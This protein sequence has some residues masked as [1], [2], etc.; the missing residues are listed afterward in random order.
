[1]DSIET[2]TLNFQIRFAEKKDANL[3]VKY[4]RELASYE[5]ELDQVTVTPDTLGKY[6]FD[7]GGAEALIGEY[8]GEPIGFAFF[9]RSFS[10]FLGKPGIALVDLYIEPYSRGNGF[11]KMMLSYLAHIAKERNCDRLEWWCHDWNTAAIERYVNW[12]ASM[13]KNIR[14][15]R[16]DGKNLNDFSKEYA[17][18]SID[19]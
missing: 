11:G 4:I 9:H 2:K 14:V 16:M 12:G 17:I 15:Y 13:V 6:M 10:T 19:K 18:Q 8:K 7:Q 5:N 1:M 3:I